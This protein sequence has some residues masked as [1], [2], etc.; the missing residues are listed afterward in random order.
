MA[1]GTGKRLWP[2]SR[3][4]RPKQVLKLIEGQTLLR[5]CVDRLTGL[6]DQRNI[7]IITNAGYADIVRE[8][9]MEIPY[10][11]VIAEHGVRDTAGAIGLADLLNDIPH[12]QD[13]VDALMGGFESEFGAEVRSGSLSDVESRAVD[14]LISRYKDPAWTWRR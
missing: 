13:T 7:I 5:R 4:S 9:L 10:G 3:Q 2:L 6:F 11:N 8:N 1:G 12:V 14:H